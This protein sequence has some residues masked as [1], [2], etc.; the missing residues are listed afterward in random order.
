MLKILILKFQ[1]SMI[2]S[3]HLETFCP[4]KLSMRV[5]EVS[6]EVT[7]HFEYSGVGF[8]SNLT[9]FFFTWNTATFQTEAPQRAMVSSTLKLKSRPLEPL[10]RYNF[11]IFEI[12]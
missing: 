6:R 3:R 4:V 10:K 11:S 8:F 7:F 9:V 2:L 1:F 12:F 5:K